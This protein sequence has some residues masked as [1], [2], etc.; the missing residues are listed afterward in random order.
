M[1][2]HP[3]DMAELAAEPL[4]PFREVHRLGEE[5]VDVL[6]RPVDRY[7]DMARWQ[8]GHDAVSMMSDNRT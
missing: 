8:E 1:I 3:L 4:R 7:A 6:D 5:A 2:G